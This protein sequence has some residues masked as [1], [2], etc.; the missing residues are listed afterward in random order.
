MNRTKP[1]RITAWTLGMAV[2][3]AAATSGIAAQEATTP[4]MPPGELVRVTV[5]NEVAAANHPELHH[6]FRSRR[7]TPK[8]SQTRLYVET[9]QALAA[10]L[11]AVNDQPV[12]AEQQMA[13]ENHLAWLMNSPEQLRKKAAR[14][15]E[16]EARSSRTSRAAP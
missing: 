15:K 3:L 6:M 4:E 10:M 5:A 13:E 9:N 11:I 7:Q 8:G 14:E 1:R 16:D 12:T 2:G